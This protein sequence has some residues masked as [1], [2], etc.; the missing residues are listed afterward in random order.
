MSA[1]RKMWA[2][3]VGR[4]KI[5]PEIYLTKREA[6]DASYWV[7]VPVRVL[8]KEIPIVKRRGKANP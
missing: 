7:G 8:V 5:E 6:V 1:Q 3:K 2:V 4:K